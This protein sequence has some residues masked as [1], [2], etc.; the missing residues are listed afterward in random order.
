MFAND[1]EVNPYLQQEVMTASPIRLRWMLIQ[2]AEELCDLVQLLWND[3]ETAKGMQWLIRIREIL[4]ELLNGVTDAENPL[5]KSVADFYVFLIQLV[6]EVEQSHS[7]ER[8]ATLKELL[9]IEKETWRQVVEKT[10]SEQVSPGAPLQDP[11]HGS[12]AGNSHISF[13]A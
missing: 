8:L 10:E 7:S 12:L 5:G 13:E 1:Q 2:R 3:G 9:L 11:S 4:G 6:T